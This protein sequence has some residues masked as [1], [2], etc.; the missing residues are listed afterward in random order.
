MA[1]A[2]GTAIGIISFGLQLYTGLSEYLDA[3]KGREEDLLQAK[4]NARTLQCSLKAIEDTMSQINGNAI[5]QDAVE[6][7]KSSCESELKALHE[8]LNNLQGKPINHSD[9]VSKAKSSIQ[10]WSYPFKKKNIARLEERLKSANNVLKTALSALQLAI[11]NDQCTAIFSLQQTVE[12]IRAQTESSPRTTEFPNFNTKIDEILTHLRS[13]ETTQT[14]VAQL[15]SYPKDLQILCDAVSNVSL[16]SEPRSMPPNPH[17]IRSITAQ[18]GRAHDLCNCAK[19][20]NIQRSRARLGLIFFERELKRTSHHAPEC[21][22]SQVVT[23]TEQKRNAVGISIPNILNILTSA[24]GVSISLTTGAGGF[25][26]AQNITWR[27]TV[28]DSLSPAFK[29]VRA[30]CDLQTWREPSLGKKEYE[31]IAKSCVRR[32]HLCYANRQASPLDMNSNGESVLDVLASGMNSYLSLGKE[33]ADDVAFVF[34]SLAAIEVPITYDQGGDLRFLSVVL[35]SAWL[36]NTNTLPETISALL[37]R[38]GEST[39]H[40]YTSVNGFDKYPK[41]RSILKEFPQIAQSLGF[42][43]LSIA[44]LR[45]DEDDVR[46]LIKRYPSF[47]MEVNYCGQSPVHIAVVVG[48]LDILSLVIGNTDPEA[49]NVMDSMKRYPIDYAVSHFLGKPKADDQHSCVSCKMVELLLDSKAVL[50]EPS[51][52][53]G[54]WEACKR[55]KTAI[56][57]HLAQRRHELEQLAVSNLPA[58]QVKDLGLCRGWTLDRNAFKVQCCLTAQSYS[59]PSYLKVHC[60]KQSVASQETPKSVYTYIL[61]RETAEYAFSLGFDR[62][63][64]FI[65]VFRRVIKNVIQRGSLGWPSPW[66]IDWILECGADL[67]STVPVDFVPGVID[68]ATW[69]HYLMSVLGYKARIWPYRL[70]DNALPQSVADDAF[71]EVLGDDCRCH[72]SSQGCTPLIKFLEGLGCRRRFPRTWFTLTEGIR[73]F[74]ASI[75]ALIAGEHTAQNWMPRAVLRYAT[76]SALGLRHTCCKHSHGGLCSIM[77]SDEI[78]EIHEEDSATLQ[79]L[80]DLVT[81]FGDGYGSM[82]TLDVFLKDVWLLKMKEVYQEMASYRITEEQLK[83]AED[84]GVKLAIA[85]SKP[86]L[87]CEPPPGSYFSIKVDVD[88]PEGH[89]DI[90][91]IGLGGWMKRF[92]EIAIDPDRPVFVTAASSNTTAVT[93]TSVSPVT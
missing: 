5:A 57:Q 65:D 45:E 19:R 4:N 89:P 62:E 76:F 22:L 71:S 21:P 75:Q 34:R 42:N 23:S 39:R 54:L 14:Q 26:L 87:G 59:V 27:P 18:R 55:T 85:D 51:L 69:A 83:K 53:Q 79:K 77:D 73:S 48:N 81:Y 80:E 11:L 52:E 12:T 28:D 91:P 74:V 1:E 9:P 2:A 33:A 58:A 82:A 31:M 49:I 17:T 15:V 37:S 56:L 63:T 8:L 43:P 38:C 64:A 13:A 20:Q 6:E 66:Y 44:V 60:D 46:F 16:R 67:T 32:L 41:R 78:D 7:C 92:D 25:S 86:A 36:L 29:L 35:E 90:I 93:Q 40:D 10:K 88:E 3:V 72:C 47:K 50:Y 30:L 84:F 61:D 24:V 70:Y 68:G